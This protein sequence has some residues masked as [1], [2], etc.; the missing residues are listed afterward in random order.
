MNV[1]EPPSFT[2]VA[3]SATLTVATTSPIVITLLVATIGPEREPV[4]ISI[5]KVSFSLLRK[6]VA[7]DL[8]KV[9]T[10]TVVFAIPTTWKLPESDPSLKSAALESSR[11]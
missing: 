8:T 2:D 3:D 7:I 6:S 9:V 11:I 10:P 1:T 4:L 5:E